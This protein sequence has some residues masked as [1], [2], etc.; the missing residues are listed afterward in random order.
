MYTHLA[1]PLGQVVA[2]VGRHRVT[3]LNF[4]VP[5]SSSL[6]EV[7]E[8]VSPTQIEREREVLPATCCRKRLNIHSTQPVFVEKEHQLGQSGL[9]VR[10]CAKAGWAKWSLSPQSKCFL[11]FFVGV[12]MLANGSVESCWLCEV[13]SFH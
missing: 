7:Q 2:A 3:S 6:K 5:F 10:I 1:I 4:K 8:R 9:D 11:P 13:H 12:L